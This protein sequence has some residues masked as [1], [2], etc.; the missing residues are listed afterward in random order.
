[1]HLWKLWYDILMYLTT[2]PMII[3][4][5]IPVICILQHLWHG[6]HLFLLSQGR[7]ILILGGQE[8]EDIERIK[9]S[10]DN[11]VICPETQCNIDLKQ[12]MY[13]HKQATRS[14]LCFSWPD[15]K[16]VWSL[17]CTT[18]KTQWLEKEIDAIGGPPWVY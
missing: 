9:N 15:Y 18:P 2:F 17:K 12:F 7:H 14:H 16:L 6:S 1:M 10:P 13:F 11:L 8:K 5:L 3:A 4:N